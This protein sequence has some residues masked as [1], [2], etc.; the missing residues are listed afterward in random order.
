M[1]YKLTEQQHQIYENI[2]EDLEEVRNGDIFGEHSWVSLKGAAGVGKTFL[3]K[4]IVKTLLEMGFNIAVVA[5][6]H[7]AVKVIRNTIGI[8]HK[9]LKFTSLHSFLG[10]KPGDINPE[11]GE[12]KFKRTAK[13]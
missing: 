13:K 8:Q 1:D 4:Q 3:N 9:K 11:T 12:R 2:I 6:T 10:L 7:Q 5:P